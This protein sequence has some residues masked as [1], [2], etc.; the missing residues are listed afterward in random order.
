MIRISKFNEAKQLL[1]RKNTL[2]SFVGSP[3]LLAQI[4]RVFGEELSP[5]QVVERIVAGVKDK[6]DEALLYYAGKL[7]GVELG[8]LEVNRQEILAAYDSVD[9]GLVAALKLAAERIRDFHY[10]CAAKRG[11]VFIN[12]Y[13]GR[14]I[15]PLSKVGLYIPGGTAA[16]PS[17]V[18]MTAIP[19]NVAGVKE[20]VMVSPP[21]KDGE[22]PAATVVAADIARVH[23][24]FKVGGAQAIAALAFGTETIPK[25]DKI[26]GPGNIFVTLAKKMVYGAADID[27]LQGPSEIMIVADGSADP[28]FCAADLLAQAEHDLLASP[29]LVTTSFGLANKIDKEVARQLKKLKRRS[30]ATQAMNRGIIVL[31]DSVDK[32]VELVNLYAPEHLSLMIADALAALPKIINAGCIFIGE[33]SAVAL[34]DYVAGPSHVLP[35]GGSAY[36]NSPLGVEDFLK[37]SNIIAFNKATVLKLGPAAMVIAKAEGLDAH[38]RSVEERMRKQGN[39]K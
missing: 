37:T 24:I 10:E 39:L 1:T 33:N 12:H 17:T 20:L 30:I 5:Q 16:Y 38:I 9:D 11:V 4:K 34:G 15:Q 18:L 13:L 32:A 25:V 2:E 3:Q 7:D 21:N 29:I 6:G 14:Q 26:C 36:F 8:F 28:S 31:V 35:T 22:I 19:A 27:G 23:R